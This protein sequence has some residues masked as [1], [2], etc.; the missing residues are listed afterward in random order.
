MVYFATMLPGHEKLRPLL[1]EKF[2]EEYSLT[3]NPV[4]D[5]V[6]E[7]L[8]EVELDKQEIVAEIWERGLDLEW[9]KLQHEQKQGIISELYL[10][11]SM[12]QIAVELG[13]EGVLRLDDE[14]DEDHIQEIQNL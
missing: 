10:R 7:R 5:F 6:V 2:W 13:E 12:R 3:T 8:A 9:G 14:F 4:L 11:Q 1:V